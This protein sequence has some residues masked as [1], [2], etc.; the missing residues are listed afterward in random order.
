MKKYFL[1]I[2]L[3]ALVVVLA[4]T[5]KSSEPA[6]TAEDARVIAK[7]AYIYGFPLV[8]SYRVQYAY[9]VDAANPEYK[10][11]WNRV[12]NTARV[13]T[14]ED[15]AVQ[16]PNSDTPYSMVGVDLRT[17]PVVISVPEVEK[18]RYYSAQLIDA[19]THNFAYLGSRATGNGAGNWL[20]A[21]PG[22]TGETPVGVGDVVR[23][24]T[25]LAL[26]V[27]RTQ[28]FNP[29]D[30]EKVKAIQEGYRVYPLSQFLGQPAPA[31]AP[32]IAFIKPLMPQEQKTSPQFFNV[33]NF[34]LQFCPP[35]PSETELMA[36][37]AKLNIGAGKTFDMAAFK[38]DIQQAI[39]HGINDAWAVC[40]SVV[41]L[42][43][44]GQLSSAECFGTREYLKND[45]TYRFAAAA[46]G[47]FGNSK[48]E[49]I[50]PAYR[51]DS[52][53]AALSG[54][55]RYTLHFAKDQLPPVN[56]FWSITMYELPASL[57]YDNA[58]DRYLINSPMLPKLDERKT[59]A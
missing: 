55:N 36:R 2:V 21:G 11:D 50:Y 24:E 48:E 52:S 26:V 18:G 15:K 7:D 23:C 12:H 46:F 25:Q 59:E 6:L 44:S 53:G 27:F 56:A 54:A 28:L 31:A 30:I 1:L 13:F 9:F 51:V 42:I 5:R 40:D 39:A 45:Y 14:P 4:C 35:H 32:E 20:L 29:A 16:T 38:P 43:G 8:D 19:Y 47:I 49:A 22:W 57:L 41:A 37:F 33:L 3:S 58:L 17:E 34:V 10:G